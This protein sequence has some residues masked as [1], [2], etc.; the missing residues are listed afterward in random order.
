MDIQ[1]IW[2]NLQ[3][4]IVHTKKDAQENL[5]VID[6]LL[7]TIVVYI[8][9]FMDIVVKD[10]NVEIS[11]KFSSLIEVLQPFVK[12]HKKRLSQF[13]QDALYQVV[14]E[15]WVREIEDPFSL[16]CP[17]SPL[18]ESIDSDNW[19]HLKPNT[20]S[21]LLDRPFDGVYGEYGTKDYF[22]PD[23][24]APIKEPRQIKEKRMTTPC[25][26]ETYTQAIEEIKKC[27]EELG[28][29]RKDASDCYR[30]DI[31]EKWNL[32]DLDTYPQYAWQWNFSKGEYDGIKQLLINHASVLKNVIEQN[33]ICC[34]LLQLYVSEW[35][36][37]DF[38]GNDRQGNAYSSLGIDDLSKEIC[39]QL[40][41]EE[42]YHDNADDT[43]DGRYTDTIYVDGGLPLNYF[44]NKNSS[45]LRK[46]I[47]NVIAKKDD[48]YKEKVQLFGKSY[49]SRG[50]IYQSYGARL[51]H[52]NDNDASIYDFIQ[53]WIVNESLNIPEYEQ[54]RKE[55][56]DG[57][58]KRRK[59]LLAE[60]F[61]VRYTV[62]KTTKYLQ[63]I[64]Q[65][66]L[67]QNA[68]ISKYAISPERLNEWNVQPQNNRFVVQI[69]D[70]NGGE[71]WKKQFDKCLAGYY[72]AFPKTDRFDLKI[73]KRLCLSK[74]DVRIDGQQITDKALSNDLQEN[75]YVKMYSKDGFSWCSQW[76]SDY[77]Y[78]AVLF[79]KNRVSEESEIDD[80]NFGWVQI[81]DSLKLTIDGKETIFYNRA[82]D[83]YIEPE[84]KPLNGYFKGRDAEGKPLFLIYSGEKPAFKVSYS[85]NGKS[86]D[87]SNEDISNKASYKFRH[88][89]SGDFSQLDTIDR[90]GYVEI[91]VKYDKNDKE[92]TI[93]CFA[94]P[95]G[96]DI[97]NY[98]D[99][100]SKRTDFK[101]FGD[102]TI[103]YKD[104][105]L[106]V[107]DN[108]VRRKYWGKIT[109][110]TEEDYHHPEAIYQITD[111]DV[112]FELSCYKPINAT[113]VKKKKGIDVG[114]KGDNQRLRLPI[115]V[116]DKII[117]QQ[118]KAKQSEQDDDTTEQNRII[119]IDKIRFRSY[120][121]N[122]LIEH[123]Y[124]DNKSLPETYLD[125]QTFTHTGDN[126]NDI[127][128]DGLN[129]VFVPTSNPLKYQ[130]V[131]LNKE[132]PRFGIDAQEEGIVVQCIK[133][134]YEIPKILLKPIY[135]PAKGKHQDL[136][137]WEK[138]DERWK[139]INKYHSDYE[140]NNPDYGDALAY[141]DV[142]T[143]T[144]MY[145]GVFDA[146]M[147]LILEKY[148]DSK[149]KKE[150]LK[151]SDNTAKHLAQ[152]YKCYREKCDKQGV[153]PKYDA[154]WRLA[155][156]FMFD[157]CLI[158]K[159]EWKKVFD[160]LTPVKELLKCRHGNI[161]WLKTAS[162]TQAI[163]RADSSINIILRTI[164]SSFTRGNGR[165]SED[166]ASFWKID[167]SKKIQ[168][169]KAIADMD[170][171][172]ISRYIQVEQ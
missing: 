89:N 108:G 126:L 143:E 40:L 2:M 62:Y 159:S 117:V 140:N 103:R 93:R 139:R 116:L 99:G 31:F 74:W 13:N 171:E 141:F 22:P 65:L 79:D 23:P 34:K 75:G 27:F 172:T 104:E 83:L 56:L 37:R 14:L 85:K 76:S 49:G 21:G 11:N 115:L 26:N 17:I 160:D 60:K 53:D 147:G 32:M 52:P 145:F 16:I 67:N 68:E 77:N 144:G 127:D 166:Q 33:T 109:E 42:V 58:E 133:N 120:A 153:S 163:N 66:Y 50:P 47:E 142:A 10:K 8:Y 72:I 98:N 150:K 110:I 154:L 134:E 78:S 92:K 107:D 71:L 69:K 111:G 119:E 90:C 168:V 124:R 156:E 155:D 87:V 137:G 43:G 61:E 51:L 41:G 29:K 20:F 3:K 91:K 128:L 15:E 114:R 64:P 136:K 162:L 70:E 95:K 28:Q 161:D 129:F 135:S 44:G 73:D 112:T 151:M 125:F 59:E 63:L 12:K 101:N 54:L 1:T 7:A 148:Y 138:R 123:N 96:A 82:G 81:E 39:E 169:L 97:K 25:D 152:F 86:E 170:S 80:E 55:L 102:L 165:N 149:E 167:L 84:C 57:G 30:H 94:V 4:H 19:V 122:A 88:G 157:W 164:T 146:M 118:L 38:N 121:L 24:N 132:L 45:N 36:K 18:F 46:A 100:N 6:E 130:P 106:S 35:Y 48:E 113:I 158:P 9:P 105:N 5:W 131:S